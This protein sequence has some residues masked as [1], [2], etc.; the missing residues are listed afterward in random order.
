MSYR[1]NRIGFLNALADYVGAYHWEDAAGY[2]AFFDFLRM[3][4]EPSLL[5]VAQDRYRMLAYATRI[6]RSVEAL[7]NAVF[8]AG[9]GFEDD[10]Y[11][12]DDSIAT[13]GR[14]ELQ[15]PPFFSSALNTGAARTALILR[16]NP[17]SHV[18]LTFPRL[19][20]DFNEDKRKRIELL[21]PGVAFDLDIMTDDAE[22][23]GKFFCLGC[24]LIR[25]FDSPPLLVVYAVSADL[26]TPEFMR[27]GSGRLSKSKL[28]N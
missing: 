2:Y 12:V 22:V 20:A 21:R 5:R 11:T 7:R 8:F 17:L 18:T 24:Q 6:H 19:A 15:V 16:S 1:K 14:Q 28:G 25:Q 27:L 26:D 4:D 9:D 3:G 13:Y 10:E 23:D